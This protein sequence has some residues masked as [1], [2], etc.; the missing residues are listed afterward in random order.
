MKRSEILELA[1]QLTERKGDNI[2]N[3]PL[4]YS[5][6]LRDICKRQRFWWRRVQGSFTMTIGTPSYDLSDTTIFTGIENIALDEITKFT[7]IL[8][9]SPLS[10][11]ELTAVFDP[12]TVIEMQQVTGNAQPTRY[13]MKPGTSQTLLIDPPDSAY[14][15]Y[16]IGWGMPNPATDSASDD[17]PLIP[18]WG[19]DTIVDGMRVQIFSQVYGD[20]HAK[21]N[22]AV[23]DFE[24]GMEDLAMR[25]KFDPNYARQLAVNG[26][27][28]RST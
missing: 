22:K 20:G 10:V 28:I 18:S 19:H 12:E 23:K 16:V 2:L 13:T 11:R 27:A 9:P 15:S 6:V 5:R 8:A 4:L 17:V 1:N 14:S 21:T 25:I 26:E 24:K 7:I 3:L